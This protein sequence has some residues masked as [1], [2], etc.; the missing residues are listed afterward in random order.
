MM[1]GTE[2]TKG[3]MR[4]QVVNN[5]VEEVALLS[6][7]LA[8][9]CVQKREGTDT[10]NMEWFVSMMNYTVSLL[11]SARDKRLFLKSLVGTWQCYLTAYYEDRDPTADDSSE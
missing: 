9:K 7:F 3:V 5:E 6:Y 11:P 8:C 2:I 10:D 4:C 1:C